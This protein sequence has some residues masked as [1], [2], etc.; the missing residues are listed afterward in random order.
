MTY[1]GIAEELVGKAQKGYTSFEVEARV[2]KGFAKIYPELF[3]LEDTQNNSPT[4]TNP[5]CLFSSLTLS[6]FFSSLFV[7]RIISIAYL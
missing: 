6:R 1:K 5:S 4:P 7:N 2:L 3:D